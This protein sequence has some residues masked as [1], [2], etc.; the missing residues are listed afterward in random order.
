MIGKIVEY[1][2]EKYVVIGFDNWE[3]CG[4][5]GYDRNYYLI[6][7]NEFDEDG[8]FRKDDCLRVHVGGTTNPV[9]VL[10]DKAPYV[11]E[12]V[13]RVVRRKQPKTIT[14]FE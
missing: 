2:S 10:E 9:K 4:S 1:K 5:C 13:I 12:K 8:L 14:I 11:L 6:P 7:L 3:D